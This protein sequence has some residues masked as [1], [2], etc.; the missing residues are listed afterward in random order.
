MIPIFPGTDARGTHDDLS[1]TRRP[2]AYEIHLIRAPAIKTWRFS[3]A[4]Y[5]LLASDL[6]N[7]IRSAI[8]VEASGLVT[9]C[10]A[11]LQR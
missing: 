1:A 4:C 6:A 8:K 11:R 7:Q 2:I 3:T 9:D 5:G 10:S